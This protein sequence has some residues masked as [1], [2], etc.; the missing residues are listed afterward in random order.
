MSAIASFNLL[1]VTALDGLRKSAVPKK[2]IFGGS[3]D[4]YWDYL[5][6]N[7]REVVNYQ[8]SGYVLGTLLCCL[9][10]D[11]Q[12]DLMRSSYDDLATFLTKAR[13]ATHFI[14][15]PEHKASYLERL[16]SSVFTT[17]SLR[18]SYNAFNATNG[19]DAGNPM[20]D[21]VHAIRESLAGLNEKSV[22]VLVIG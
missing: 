18:D 7:G 14:L 1:P 16:N 9:K 10:D 12:V 17:E 11:Y 22:V 5:R 20:L 21:G 13:R 3:K 8:W 6:R 2:R 19:P 4:T 15:S